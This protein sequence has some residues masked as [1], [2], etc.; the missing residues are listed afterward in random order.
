MTVVVYL[1]RGEIMFT[2]EFFSILSSFF[3]GAAFAALLMGEHAPYSL[4]KEWIMVYICNLDF[5]NNHMDTPRSG[6][7]Y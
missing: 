5:F 6:T 2:A 3:V 4:Y 1:T 7:C